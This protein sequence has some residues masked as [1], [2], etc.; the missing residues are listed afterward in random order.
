MKSSF[1]STT[2]IIF[3]I[4][5]IFF[6]NSVNSSVQTHYLQPTNPSR[7]IHNHLRYCDSFS[8]RNPRSLC[9]ELQKMHHGLNVP[10]PPS[11][12][13][14]IDPRYGVEKRLVPSGPNPLHN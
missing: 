9:I 8:R 11:M 5:Y 10:P 1:S 4:L 14:G 12:E 2:V 6:F 13:N 7:T 3:I